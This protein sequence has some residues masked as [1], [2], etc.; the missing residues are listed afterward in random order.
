MST[1]QAENF[2]SQL[3]RSIDGTHHNVSVQHLPRYLAASS[4]LSIP[5]WSHG[6][7]LVIAARFL[8]CAKGAFAA[9]GLRP[10]DRPQDQ[11]PLR[12]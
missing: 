8:K 1:N 5:T 2:F 9:H 6:R 3:K 4:V 10:N 11:L 7:A 12:H